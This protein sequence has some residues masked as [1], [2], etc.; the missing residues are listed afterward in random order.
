V[1]VIETFGL[2]KT[3]NG[4]FARTR[5]E[6]LSGVDLA[7]PTGSAF[8]LIGPNGAGK[9]TFI[10]AILGIVRPTSG[11]ARLMGGDPDDPAVRQRVGYLPERLQ[12]PAAWTARAFLAS[13]ARIKSVARPECCSSRGSSRDIARSSRRSSK[14]DGAAPRLRR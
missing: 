12:L 4:L 6:A 14:R 9:T 13:I 7:V 8:G 2:K 5:Q 10:K 1:F 11:K 3:Y